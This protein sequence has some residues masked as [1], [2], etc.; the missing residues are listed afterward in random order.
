MHR[1]RTLHDINLRRRIPIRLPVGCV[2]RFRLWYRCRAV[3]CGNTRQAAAC[4]SRPSTV[5][6]SWP[7]ERWSASRI[8]SSRLIE[9]CPIGSVQ[10]LVP[11][12]GASG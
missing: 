4:Y 5:Q 6:I 7:C 10:I 11:F 9:C 12:T 3:F 2:L 1:F 8:I